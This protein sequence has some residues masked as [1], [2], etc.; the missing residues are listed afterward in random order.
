[1]Q[2]VSSEVYQ[3]SDVVILSHYKQKSYIHDYEPLYHY[4]HFN[5]HMRP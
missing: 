5:V 1:M 2:E 3:M 4:E